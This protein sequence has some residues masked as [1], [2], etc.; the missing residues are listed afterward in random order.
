[1]GFQCAIFVH[2]ALS[3]PS[4]APAWDWADCGSDRYFLHRDALFAGARV[5]YGRET[6]LPGTALRR[7]CHDYASIPHRRRSLELDRRRLRAR[8]KS[9]AAVAGHA[10][11]AGS[12]D[13]TV[14]FALILAGAPGH[15]EAAPG[16]DSPAGKL[17]GIAELEMRC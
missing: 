2:G 16:H 4:R 9:A 15:P 8:S 13:A 3:A 6:V 12:A 11:C 7:P 1:M 14:I 10:Q 5:T 17:F